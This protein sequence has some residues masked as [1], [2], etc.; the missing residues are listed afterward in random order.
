MNIHHL[1]L[2]YHVARHGGIMEAVRHMPYG[3]QQPAVSGQLLQLEAHLG[4]KLFRR[5]PFELLPPGA[6]LYGFIRPF[7][8]GLGPMEQRLRTGA[9]QS[10]RIAAPVMALRDH[11]PRVLQAVRA[12]FPRLQLG[13][14][15]GTQPQVESWLERQEIDFAITLLEGQAAKGLQH[16]P[17]L[18]LPLVLL[19]PKASRFRRYQ[20]ILEALAGESLDEPLVTVGP[21]EAAPRRFREHLEGLSLE[22][23]GRVEVTDLELV[24]AYVRHGFGIGLG[25][26]IPGRPADRDLRV[27]PVEG[28]PPLRLGAVWRGAPTDAMSALMDIL[29]EHVGRVTGSGGPAIDRRPGR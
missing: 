22:W 2:F 10:L 5:R 14:R 16:E 18:D 26:S 21:S 9:D 8:E 17:L 23:A 12:R 29:R 27:L 25:L 3:I 20:D 15:S 6:E 24:D 19:V 4:V 11:L 1:E 28:V 13:L 7:F